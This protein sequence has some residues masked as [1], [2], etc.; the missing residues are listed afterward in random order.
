MAYQSSAR[1]TRVWMDDQ[2][3]RAEFMG[4]AVDGYFRDGQIWTATL[5]PDGR[6]QHLADRRHLV[7]GRWFFRGAVLCSIPNEAHRPRF[8]IGCWSIRKASTNCYEYFRV[9]A[10]A[11]EP[12]EAESTEWE[13]YALGWRQGEAS[14]CS[15]KPT[16]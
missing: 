9:R 2:A 8:A 7:P 10:T 4:K 6:V 1:A 12:L 14:T 16:V 3:V 15:E 13:W 5:A 11:S